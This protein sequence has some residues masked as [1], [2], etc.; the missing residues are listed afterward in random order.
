M[1]VVGM[2]D[3]TQVQFP[4]DMPP[5]QIKSMILAKFPGAAS[6]AAAPAAPVAAPVAGFTPGQAPTPDQLAGLAANWGKTASGTA[7]PAWQPPADNLPA[8]LRAFS[9]GAVESVPIIGALAH[10][11]R[12]PM[13]QAID[14][15]AA[16]QA[17]AAAAA[18]QVFGNVAPFMAGGEIPGVAKALGMDA[19]MGLGAQMGAGAASMAGIS[20]IDAA[21]RGQTPVQVAGAAGLGAAG[22]ALGP[23]IGKVV[24]AG[25]DAAGKAIGGAVQRARAVVDPGVAKAIADNA[26]TNAAVGDIAS[27][28]PFLNSFDEADAVANG[29]PL[30]NIDRYGEGVRT[31]GRAAGNLSPDAKATLTNMTVPR[32]ADTNQRAIGFVQNLFGDT[33]SFAAQQATQNAARAANK[34][35]YLKAYNDPAA[36]AVFNDDLA[37]LMQSEAVRKAV[38]GATGTAS[39]DAA[40]HGFPA[41]KNPFRFNSD[42]SYSLTKQAD[43]SVATPSLQF[44]DY[45]QRNL[46]DNA[47]AA[48]RAGNPSKAGQVGAL[49]TQL[50]GILDQQVPAFQQARQ[51]AAGFFNAQDAL[52]AGKNFTSMPLSQIPGAQQAFSGM[53]APEQKLFQTGFGGAL[54]DKVGQ[55]AQNRASVIDNIFTSPQAKAQIQL[56]MGDQGA[57]QME[58]F[59]RL[60]HA[61]QQSNTAV[62]RGSSTMAQRAAMIALQNAPTAASGYAGGVST[63]GGFNPMAWKPANWG[64]A[65][66]FAAAGRTGAQYLGSKVNNAVMANI[67]QTLASR[68]PAAIQQLVQNSVRSPQTQLAIKAIERGMQ[69]MVEGVT[70]AGAPAAAADLLPGPGGQEQPTPPLRIT[71]NGATP[72]VQ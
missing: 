69:T 44:W 27:G 64:S 72:A 42:G 55:V 11:S 49:R 24:G 46:G 9:T 65:A 16:Q 40:L 56:A 61:M 63:G 62:A 18:G 51:G 2:P 3:G 12:D 20:G 34:P 68:D 21:L 59:L 29:Q 19:G 58:S 17:P 48:A 71:V 66:A 39:N 33:N 8:P 1:P 70:G 36:G 32:Q 25:V 53:T 41:V 4:D 38:R 13:M 60:E 50:N 15:R 52:E 45:V 31:L 30:A 28:Q 23:V 14:A 10:N 22:G 26:V 67:A 35:A 43:G 5:A 7:P 6:T 47:S 37:Q 57:Q 54:I